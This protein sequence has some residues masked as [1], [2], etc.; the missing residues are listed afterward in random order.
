MR[1]Q[2]IVLCEPGV[3][4]G[5]QI[6][7]CAIELLAEGHP[8]EL[9]ERG[10]VE[11]LADAVGL[12]ALRLGAGM[13]DVLH[14]QVELVLVMLGPAAILRAAIGQHTTQRNPVLVVER[15]HPVVEEI[16]RRDRRLAVVELG[17][18]VDEGLLVDPTD[19]LERADVEGVLSRRS[20]RDA[21][22]RTRRAPPCRS[23]PSRAPRPAPRSAPGPPA[24][25]WPRAPSAASWCSPG[26]GAATRS[27]RRRARPTGRA[28]STRLTPA[29]GPRS[30][31]RAP[32]P[33]PPSRSPAPPG[34]SRSA[35][36]G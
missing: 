26:R 24:P 19:T 15:Q 20:S 9:V 34:S 21:R 23:W 22:F 6:V 33:P 35:C 13:V 27:A 2:F 30:A 31:V 7:D 25:S 29:P 28:S 10:R 12:R 18:G 3:K 14:R 4:V 17:V 1:T 5:L 16:G 36:G 8:I 32:S 11:A